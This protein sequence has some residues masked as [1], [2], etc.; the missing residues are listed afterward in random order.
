[1]KLPKISKKGTVPDLVVPVVG[2]IG[3]AIIMMAYTGGY[4]VEN[5]GFLDAIKNTDAATALMYAD[6]FLSPL[7]W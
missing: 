5:I 4:F 2:L 1:V 6:F 3:F 7:L